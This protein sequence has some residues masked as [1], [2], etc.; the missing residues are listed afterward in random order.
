MTILIQVRLSSDLTVVTVAPVQF[1]T[2]LPLLIVCRRDWNRSARRGATGSYVA[3]QS[4][5][6]A[7]KCQITPTAP[8]YFGDPTAGRDAFSFSYR[9]A[10]GCHYQPECSGWL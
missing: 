5:G 6:I 7:V 3:E 4:H 8:R 2:R 1:L 10:G 9:Y